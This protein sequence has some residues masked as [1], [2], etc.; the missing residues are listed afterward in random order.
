MRRKGRRVLEAVAG[1]V[2]GAAALWGV[3][4]VSLFAF[5]AAG[6]PD[7]EVPNGDPCC[8][9]PDNWGEVVEGGAFTAGSAFLDGLLLVVA[10]ALLRHA[11]RGRA[12]RRRWFVVGPA[13]YAAAAIL[14]VAV[15]Q[16]TQL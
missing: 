5:Y 4:W 13:L 14:A 6:R 8:G 3:L 11:V 12:L 9:H 1:L 15:A 7:P 16:L 2:I 10:V